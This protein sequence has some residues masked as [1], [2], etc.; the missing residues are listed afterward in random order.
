[1]TICNEVAHNYL[2]YVTNSHIYDH[3]VMEV[4]YNYKTFVTK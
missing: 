1:M 4:A 2:Q 3:N